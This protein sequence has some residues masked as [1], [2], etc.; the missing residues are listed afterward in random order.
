MTTLMQLKAHHHP[1]GLKTNLDR[2]ETKLIT[3]WKLATT[4]PDAL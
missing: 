3:K 4:T 2:V 1:I